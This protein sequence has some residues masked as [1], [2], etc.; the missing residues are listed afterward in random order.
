MEGHAVA[1]GTT[2]GRPNKR[3]QRTSAGDHGAGGDRSANAP[4]GPASAVAR[5]ARR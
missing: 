3:L 2:A 1:L 4:G 5:G